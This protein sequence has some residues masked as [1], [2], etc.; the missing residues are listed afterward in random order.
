MKQEAPH[1]A[2]GE[3]ELLSVTHG[4]A[5]IPSLAARPQGP[6]LTTELFPS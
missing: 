2:H 1:F 3:T 5:R 4:K 6:T